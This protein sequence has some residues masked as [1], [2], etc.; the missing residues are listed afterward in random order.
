MSTSVTTF[1]NIV[2]QHEIPEM[3]AFLLQLTKADITPVRLRTKQFYREMNDWDSNERRLLSRKEPLLFLAG[4]A[5]YSKLEGLGRNFEFPIDFSNGKDKRGF[6]AHFMD[7]VRHSRPTW[8]TAWL[9]RMARSNADSTIN[10]GLLR[11]LADENLVEYDPWLFAQSSAHWLSHHNRSGNKDLGAHLL[12]QLQANSVLLAR[13]LPL[14][15]DFDTPADSASVYWSNEG[16]VYATKDKEAVDISWLTLLPQLAKSGHLDRADL[17]TRSLLALRRDF[18][19]GLLIWFK[20]IFLA[21]KST[22]AERLARQIELVELLA[23]PLPLVVNFAIEQLKDL[24][25]EP[26]FA[27]APLLLYADALMTRQDLKTGMKTLLSGFGKLLKTNPDQA[28]AFARLYAAALTHPDTAVQ[29]RAAN[30]LVSLLQ[31]KE[32][33]LAPAE[34]AEIIDNIGLYANLLTPAT[35]TILAPWLEEA[36]G[37]NPA[38]E[39]EESYAPQLHFVP[40]ISAATA[41]VPVR[42]WHELLFLTGQVLHHDDTL[43][44]ERWLDGLLRLRPNFPANY[45][46]LLQP[47]VMQILPYL[48]GSEAELIAAMQAITLQSGYSGLV[49][50]LMLAWATGFAKPLVSGIGV[51]NTTLG[52]T[53]PLLVV[54]QE[55]LG[56]VELQL[57]AG[58]PLPLLSTPTHA[59]HWVAPTVLVNRLLAY[60]VAQQEPNMADLVVALARTAFAH[61]EE[62]ETAATQLLQLRHEGLREL[63][64]WLLK[65][66]GEPLPAAATNQKSVLKQFTARLERL[67]PAPV[68]LPASLA[69][70]L[71]WLW[72]VAARTKAPTAEYPELA[73]LT[74][75]PCPGVV[76]AWQPRWKFWRKSNTYVAQWKPD[77][78]EVTDHWTELRVLSDAPS[79][80]PNSLLL[81]SLHA[82]MKQGKERDNWSYV[83]ALPRDY[84][85]LVTLLPQHPAP[86][87]WQALRLAATRDTVDSTHRDILSAALRSLLVPGP[88][89]ETPATLLLAVGLT[90]NATVCRALALEALLAAITQRRLMPAALGLVLGRLLAAEYA[91]MQRLTDALAQTR[92]IGP[93]T[94][95]ALRQ[96]LENLLPELPAAPIRNTAK[97]LD[98]YTNVRGQQPLPA[99]VQTRLREW[100]AASASLKKVAASLLKTP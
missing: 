52:I 44:L 17:L 51:R 39:L 9:Q 45:P 81:Y 7:M 78:P 89:L 34:A 6:K 40:E 49:Q 72:A 67:L 74:V 12:R 14:L 16:A 13:E 15:F 73:S 53:D 62:A 79:V 59:P 47:Y 11:E 60:E 85:F 18:R 1:E 20:N 10:Y 25:A 88:A 21:L 43:A 99:A 83:W 58:Q 98:A 4:L 2:R 61:A 91:P 92:A 22:P 37:A 93:A 94:D 36:T 5:T 75:A 56:F 41:I 82:S 87:N 95:D 19:R 80:A 68:A 86:L 8:L 26:D 27:A 38:A 97:L 50:A 33:L 76:Q 28:L 77:K 70:A 3:V 35:R 100:Q 30:G 32:P 48:R 71:P 96:V 65:P 54:A 63:L 64:A 23:H 69:E 90:H 84:P 46:E 24:W 42:D 66:I 29:E 31:A 57:H 55:R